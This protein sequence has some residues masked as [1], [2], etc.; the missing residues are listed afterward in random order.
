[1]KNL[2]VLYC[3]MD[4]YIIMQINAFML[5]SPKNMALLYVDAL[6]LFRTNILRICET[7][8]YLTSIFKMKDM[9]EVDTSLGIKIK[10]EKK[11]VILTQSHYIEKMLTKYNYLEI[12]EFN[13]P[14]DSSVKL[15][16]KSGRIVA[17]LQYASITSSMMY[18]MYC[19]RLDI[20][21]A[22]CKL[23]T[24]MSKPSSDH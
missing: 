21:F 10:R 14:Y 1:M 24:V 13:T 8:K 16:E 12:K 7:K 3:Q 17:Q 18:A 2:I 22:V 5:S 20:A 23:S 6:L 19:T 9:N 11:G 4:S 15:I